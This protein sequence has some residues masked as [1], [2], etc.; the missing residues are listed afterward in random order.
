MDPWTSL[1]VPLFLLLCAVGL[2]R[3][4]VRTWRRFQGQPLEDVERDYR[5]RQFRRRMQSSAMLAVLAVAILIGQL[6]TGPPV[7]VIAYWGGV[8]LLLGWVGLLALADILATKYHF[9]R[10][11]ETYL[12]ERAKLQAQLRRIQSA[13]G[14]G[15]AKKKGPDKGL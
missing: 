3:L 9:G 4:H 13:R 6:I 1:L 11:R 10:L 2:I 5:R 8:L 15:K 12:I 14:N 7:L